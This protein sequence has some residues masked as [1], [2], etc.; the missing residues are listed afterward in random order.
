[1]E[2]RG[3]VISGTLIGGLIL[4]IVL[5]MISAGFSYGEVEGAGIE[6]DNTAGKEQREAK[7]IE[8][9][10]CE[11]SEKYPQKVR[12]WCGLMMENGEKY[13]VP[14]DLIAAVM[15]Q[16]SGGNP[17]AYSR[18]GAVGL[19]QVMPRDG[20]AGEYMCANGP[21][22]EG[23]PLRKELEDPAY[24][25]KYG[26]KMLKRLK[27]REG[28]WREALAAYGPGDAGYSYADKVLR[29]YKSYK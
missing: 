29:I 23:R 14:V 19:L 5:V 8:G 21:C 25:L 27:E 3:M 13:G 2:G 22:F 7:A 12:R 10:E 4:G 26:V 9:G 28:N 18:S 1:M 11:V 24:N 6:T 16:E 15:L 17:R 20:R